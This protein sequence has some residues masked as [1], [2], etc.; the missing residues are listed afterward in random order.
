MFAAVKTSA[1][2]LHEIVKLQQSPV[3]PCCSLEAEM[4]APGKGHQSK[5]APATHGHQLTRQQVQAAKNDLGR[6][7]CLLVSWRQGVVAELL[8]SVQAARCTIYL[9]MYGPPYM[10]M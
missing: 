6:Y 8:A 3:V 4:A 10:S 2:M 9:V 1:G 5:A 7:A